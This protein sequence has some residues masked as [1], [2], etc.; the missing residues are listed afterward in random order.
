MKWILAAIAVF[1]VGY[2]LVNIYFRKPGR[3]YRPY[4]DAQN[5]ATTSRLLAAGW[6]KMPVDF[7]RPAEPPD[8]LDSRGTSA[9][10][11]SLYRRS[12][13]PLERL[14][15]AHRSANAPAAAPRQT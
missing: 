7:R 10:I 14:S 5:R 8:V 15:P 3:G 13:G 9:D 6:Q 2:T 4:Q 12:C 1:I 11:V